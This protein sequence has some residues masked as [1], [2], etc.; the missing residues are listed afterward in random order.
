MK[1]C[2]AGVRQRKG[3]SRSMYRRAAWGDCKRSYWGSI[4]FGAKNYP[5]IVYSAGGRTLA[6]QFGVQ[7]ERQMRCRK[8]M[9]ESDSRA[10][11]QLFK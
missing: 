7:I 9:V 11:A 4:V 10:V 1:L 5:D 6:I 3:V 2:R 8:M